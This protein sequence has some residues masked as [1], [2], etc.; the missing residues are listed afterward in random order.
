MKKRE[1]LRVSSY[2]VRGAYLDLD[3]RRE[4]PHSDVEL[5]NA[6]VEYRDRSYEWGVVVDIKTSSWRKRDFDGDRECVDHVQIYSPEVTIHALIGLTMRGFVHV[7]KL[8]GELLDKDYG[9]PDAPMRIMKFYFRPE[10][11]LTDDGEW[12]AD[13]KPEKS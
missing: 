4:S 11:A 12:L 7:V 2:A 8:D 9:R 3:D 6:V 10:S 5:R 1:G 13:R